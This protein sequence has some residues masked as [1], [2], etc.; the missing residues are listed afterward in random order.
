MKTTDIAPI[1][2]RT[3]PVRY[4]GSKSEFRGRLGRMDGSY[5]YR[6]ETRYDLVLT[7]T[8]TEPEVRL[9]LVRRPSMVIEEPVDG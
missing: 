2:P 9:S 4:E 3:G 8:A 5:S 6:G 1:T 7:E